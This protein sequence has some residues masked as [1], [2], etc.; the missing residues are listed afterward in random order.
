MENMNGKTNDKFFDEVYLD[1]IL[2]EKRQ[3]IFRKDIMQLKT[4]KKNKLYKCSN[5]QFAY[6]YYK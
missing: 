2:I 5:R 4:N 6:K 3:Y 1:E